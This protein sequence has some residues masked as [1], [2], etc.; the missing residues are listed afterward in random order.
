M[1]IRI[2]GIIAVILPVTFILWTINTF[3]PRQQAPVSQRW[4]GPIDDFRGDELPPG[5]KGLMSF[6]GFGRVDK[7]KTLSST[8]PGSEWD[9]KPAKATQQASYKTLNNASSTS[10]NYTRLPNGDI[11][12]LIGVMSPQW[13]SSRRYIIRDAY[14][15]FPAALPVDVVF[16]HG[17]TP[18]WSRRNAAKVVS[19]HR[20]QMLWENSTFHDILYL[21]CEENMEEGKTYEYF[22]KVGSEFSEKYTHVMKTDDDS[23]VNIPG[24]HILENFP[25]NLQLW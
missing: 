20:T 14:R 8:H 22:K 18:T 11:R 10:T 6:M 13:S 24:I 15:R 5:S 16:V 25:S 21:D 17:E 12:L 4:E 23:F 1:G 9:V 3:L 19:T 7:E 2:R